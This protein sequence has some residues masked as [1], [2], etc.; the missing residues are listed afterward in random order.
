MQFIQGDNRLQTYFS[1]S[2]GL[3]KEQWIENLTAQLFPTSYYHVV[4]TV[5]HDFN[6]LIP[7]NRKQVFALLFESASAKLI[8]FCF[9][10]Q[11]LSASIGI[12][13]GLFKNQA[14]WFFTKPW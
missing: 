1:R 8:Q 13:P 11:H 7:G 2:G 12:S 10:P 6:G 14:L 4:F 9:D 5:P 3:K